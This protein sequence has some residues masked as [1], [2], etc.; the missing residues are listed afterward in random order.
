MEPRL[1]FDATADQAATGPELY[2]EI[3]SVER[4][5]NLRAYAGVFRPDDDTL[6]TRGGSKGLRIYDEC[7]RDGHAYAVLNKRRM[8][9]VARDWVVEP[10]S[11][12]RTD[13]KAADLVRAQLAALN[14]DKLT[15][16][17]LDATLKGYA[18]GEV[19]WERD[20]SLI[21]AK[22]VI[23]RDQRRFTFDVAGLPRLL[24]RENLLTGI[25]LPPRKFICHSFGGKDENPHGLGLGSKLYWY[26]WFKRQVLSSWLIFIEKF[27]SPTVI[28]EYP[29]GTPLAEQRRLLSIAGA[30]A[31]EAAVAIPQG[32]VLR[33]MEAGRTGG[34]GAYERFLRY[35]D[36]QISECVLGETLS[37]NQGT[38]GS[39]AATETHDGVRKELAKADADLLSP[40]L[41]ESIVTWIVEL[42]MPDAA[43][44]TVYRDFSEPEDLDARADR[45]VKIKALGYVPTQ[46]YI[47]DTYGEGFLPAAPAAPLPAPVEGAPSVPAPEF[48]EPAPEAIDGFAEQLDQAMPA[49]MGR[50]LAPIRDL[51]AGAGSLEELRDALGGVYEQIDGAAFASLMSRAGAAGLM[52]GRYEVA[53]G[54]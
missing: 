42:N 53:D 10:A 46:A 20:G 33:L 54:R 1:D 50:M 27:A 44:P 2:N 51:V 49:V 47:D 19:M 11:A 43:P 39:Q 16:D 28:G 36:E 9:V 41:R 13:K 18:V 30:I 32:L 17:Q 15:T 5:I 34:E 48:R 38:G 4:D 8:A 22:K 14:F 7:E 25:E 40:T 26:C 31:Q 24:V 52:M 6:A 12:S 29:P 23:P 35:C 45:D 3:A 37:T 21:V